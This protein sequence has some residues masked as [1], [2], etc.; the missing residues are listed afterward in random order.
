MASTFCADR[1][2][3]EITSSDTAN[4]P[5]LCPDCKVAGCEPYRPGDKGYEALPS[6]MRECQRL[7]A[8]G[9]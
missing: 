5:E 1:D 7:D 6:H 2:C 8:Y 9:G 4:K 3:F